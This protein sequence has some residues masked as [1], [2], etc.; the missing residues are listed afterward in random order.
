LQ[1]TGKDQ[2]VVIDEYN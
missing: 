1:Q 2:T